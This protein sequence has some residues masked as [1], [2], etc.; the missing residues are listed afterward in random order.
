M[1]KAW[2][3]PKKIPACRENKMPFFQ[4]IKSNIEN[5]KSK[6][7]GDSFLRRNHV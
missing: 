1:Y 4:Q 3:L 5:K 7:R 6:E 2:Y